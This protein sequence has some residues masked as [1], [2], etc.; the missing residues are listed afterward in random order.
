MI[1]MIGEMKD[2]ISHTP[3]NNVVIKGSVYRENDTSEMYTVMFVK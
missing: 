2:Y 1:R 3:F